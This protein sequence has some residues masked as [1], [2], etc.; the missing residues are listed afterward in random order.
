[1]SKGFLL[2]VIICTYNRAELLQGALKTLNDQYLP[3]EEYQIIVVD[4]GSTD[5]TEKVGREAAKGRGERLEYYRIEHAGRSAARNKGIKEAVGDYVLFVDDD[6][7]AP[8]DLLEEHLNAHKG[9]PRIVV[10]G[11]IINVKQYEIPSD[12]STTWRDYSSAFFCTCNASVS[13]FGLLQVGG[14]DES[15]TEY[16]F[17][18]NELGWRLREKGWVMNF[19]MK[20][21]VYHYKPERPRERLDEIIK[22][23]RELGRSAVAYYNKHPHW[24]V[25]LAT[26]LHPILTPWN[27]LCGSPWVLEKCMQRWQDRGDDL[28]PKERS[29]LEGRI[30]Q[31][32][33]LSSLEEARKRLGPPSSATFDDGPVNTHLR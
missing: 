11:P 24:K 21:V 2:S 4:D 12:L 3:R 29:F 17:E 20:A 8:P 25:G 22:M 23:A 30:F 14:F 26:G 5:D 13:R 10:R 32:Y 7:L 27:K 1:V 33:Y 18:D 15:F 9:R 19:N 31:Y 6:I 16:G 28:S